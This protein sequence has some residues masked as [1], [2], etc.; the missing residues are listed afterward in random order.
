MAAVTICSDFGDQESK[1]YHCFHCFHI[2]WPWSDGTG[3]RDLHFLTIEFSA[4]SLTFLFCLS[5]CFLPLEHN[6]CEG[7]VSLFSS[8]ISLLSKILVRV[9]IQY[10]LNEGIPVLLMR[11]LRIENTILSSCLISCSSLYFW[12]LSMLTC[13]DL[14]NYWHSIT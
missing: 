11:K 4:V 14:I 5:S 2:Y 12:D 9:V 6:L 7:R 1:V 3:C 8:A 13:I 10:F